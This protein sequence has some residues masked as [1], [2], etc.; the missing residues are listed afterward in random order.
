MKINL[1]RE[2]PAEKIPHQ[3]SEKE[4]L[5]FDD[6]FQQNNDDFY[7]QQ[8]P[9]STEEY[10]RPHRSRV[11]LYI[12]L[13]LIFLLAGAFIS[14]PSGTRAFFVNFGSNVAMLWDKGVNKIGS[15]FHRGNIE[16][17]SG[18]VEMRTEKAVPEAAPAKAAE[19]PV[20]LETPVIRIEKPVI[21]E[22]VK[23]SVE[24]KILESPAIY[25]KIRND[26]AMSYRNLDI[27]E[28]I[29]SK[30][31]GGMTPGHLDIAENKVNI[32]VES[33]NPMLI[34][35]YAGIIRQQD[36][37]RELVA[38]EPEIRDDI[39][40]MQLDAELAEAD[41]VLRPERIWDLDVS[42]F[43]DYL[44]LAAEKTGVEVLMD[45]LDTRTAE[46]GILEH[47][48][49]ISISGSTRMEMMSFFQ[50]LRQVPAAYVIQSISAVY[51]EKEGRFLTDITMGYYERE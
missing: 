45:L 37:F 42:W 5:N 17:I 19:N 46:T 16:D 39:I 27:A 18:P 21:R 35:S 44:K 34:Q 2:D 26:I 50:E 49:N 40:S 22:V 1:L 33:R 11:W 3:D 12:I 48:I 36:M 28:Y 8:P 24:E 25:D 6:T 14:N 29:W 41:P 43:D 32:A 13:L 23:E 15:W 7:F 51:D 10:R 38:S 30:M 31:P 9:A 4:A 20:P 47:D